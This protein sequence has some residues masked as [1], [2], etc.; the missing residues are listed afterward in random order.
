MT[1][2]LQL[3]AKN[4]RLDMIPHIVR[5]FQEVLSKKTGILTGIVHSATELNDLEKSEIKQNIE[6]KLSQKVELNFQVKKEMIGGIEAKV[7]KLYF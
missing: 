6:S 2:F 3:L 5:A 4:S 1:T 7:G